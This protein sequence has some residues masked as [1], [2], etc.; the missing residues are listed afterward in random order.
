MLKRK[1]E[2]I[3]K[4]SLTLTSVRNPDELFDIAEELKTA[5]EERKQAG[6]M[7]EQMAQHENV[8]TYLNNSNT[9]A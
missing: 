1:S 3:I 8:L 9:L 2:C 4:Y 7:I 6:M 5:N